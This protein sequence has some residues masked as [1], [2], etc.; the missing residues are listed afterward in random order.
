MLTLKTNAELQG[1]LNQ[2]NLPVAD[3]Y[4]F[5]ELEFSQL[6]KTCSELHPEYSASR[7]EAWAAYSILTKYKRP[8]SEVSISAKL[9]IINENLL[10]IKDANLKAIAELT[11]LTAKSKKSSAITA[12]AVC[13]IAVLALF[14]FV[15]YAK[16]QVPHDPILLQGLSNG[17]LLT[18]AIGPVTG[19]ATRQAGLFAINC[20][21]GMT[22]TWDA[23]LSRMTLEASGVASGCGPSGA[24][25]GVLTDNGLGDCTTETN[26]TFNGTTL[27]VTG[28]VAATTITEG[29]NGVP[30]ST[31]HLG[32]FAATTSAQL[33]GVLNDED[34]TGV[35]IFNNATAFNA[36]TLTENSNAVPNATDHLGFF[37]ATTSAQLRGVLSD[38]KGTGEAIFNAASTLSFSGLTLSDMTVGSILFAGTAGLVSQS[39]TNFFWNNDVAASAGQQLRVGGSEGQ[40]H[41]TLDPYYNNAWYKFGKLGNGDI[42]SIGLT[43][44]FESSGPD[45]AYGLTAVVGATNTALNVTDDVAIRGFAYR[46]GAG[47]TTSELNASEFKAFCTLGTCTTS[48][49]IVI[50]TTGTGGTLGTIAALDIETQSGATTNLAIR[51]GAS[52]DVRLGVLTA[53]R[54]VE[55][56]ADKD[57]TSGAGTCITSAGLTDFTNFQHDH[58]DADDGGALAASTVGTSQVTDGSLL[59]ADLDDGAD[60]PGDE[61]CLTYEATGTIFEWQACSAGGATAWDDIAD[62]DAD[63]SIDFVGFEQDIIAQN[64]TA[65]DEIFE[66][67]NQDAD[68]ANTVTIF[69]ISDY[70]QDDAQ[71]IYFR[72]VSD[73]D[74]TPR[75]DYEF[76]QSGAS[77]VK[78]LTLSGGTLTANNAAGNLF[79]LDDAGVA[80]KIFADADGNPDTNVASVGTTGSDHLLLNSGDISGSDVIISPN[81]DVIFQE[82]GGEN[83]ILDL[84][85]A[86]TATVFST[87][88]LNLVNFSSIDVQVP[89]EAYGAGWNGSTEVPTKNAVYDKIETMG[90]GTAGYTV[91]LYADAFSPADSTT[92]Y[93]ADSFS[94]IPNTSATLWKVYLPIA[95]TITAASCHVIISGALGTT[96]NVAVS[97]RVNNTTDASISATAQYTAAQVNFSNLAMSQAVSANDYI[98]IKVVAP[99]WST[100]P[101]TVN[102]HC[103]IFV[104][105]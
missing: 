41:N 32:F 103:T 62:P 58:G 60:T 100:N 31:D 96:E 97:V 101:T 43:A 51:T 59:P 89:D 75:V 44:I 80:L 57:L 95:G 48:R 23:A 94:G 53:S 73:I 86:N 70:D 17:T 66:I 20:S 11:K 104:A 34:G 56:D 24:D 87:S 52:G 38:E 65:N 72:M 6:I 55:T 45:S 77:F 7:R 18:D 49:G 63:G 26:L 3:S 27:T 40:F 98:N 74:G 90:G 42:D 84:N 82:T 79:S 14:L 1:W 46:L 4:E 21:T 2:A 37:A 9:D 68:R 12:I 36:T 64:D 91:Q 16:S 78:N 88:G 71:A 85:T 47:G 33:R 81:D 25:N 50:R 5:N 13:V 15:G 30:N 92:Y 69:Q 67:T 61:E 39:N 83:L 35:A 93:F 105:T 54:C 28:T 99:A 76:G 29:G 19:A 10:A 102:Q 8:D 22:C